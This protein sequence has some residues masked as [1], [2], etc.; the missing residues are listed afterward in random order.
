MN[1][2]NRLL[3]Q[4]LFRFKY[5]D[6]LLTPGELAEYK[7]HMTS[8]TVSNS[9]SFTEHRAL[10]RWID[11]MVAMCQPERIHWCSGSEE[12][13]SQLFSEMTEKGCA[14]D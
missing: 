9:E 5:S 8:M 12:E 13:S 1:N 14:S 7:P 3:D 10:R 4:G 11:K 2:A 6:F